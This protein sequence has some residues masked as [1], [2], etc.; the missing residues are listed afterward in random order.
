M[1][2]LCSERACLHVGPE[3]RPD[4]GPCQ[5]S[6]FRESLHAAHVRRLS[7]AN[8][9]TNLTFQQGHCCPGLVLRARARRLPF[10]SHTEGTWVFLF[11]FSR[12]E[13]SCDCQQFF[14]DSLK[15]GPKDR[16]ERA[17]EDKQG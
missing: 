13:R 16:V 14:K 17:A 1:E 5:A 9:R 4:K 8:L 7:G 15:A 10:C 12:G 6:V 2:R 11:V 3:S